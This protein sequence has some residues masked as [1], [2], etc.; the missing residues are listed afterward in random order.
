MRTVDPIKS[1]IHGGSK[2]LTVPLTMQVLGSHMN[3]GNYCG[4]RPLMKGS[5]VSGLAVVL[6]FLS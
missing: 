6:N 5:P 4:R 1:S 3:A 2:R